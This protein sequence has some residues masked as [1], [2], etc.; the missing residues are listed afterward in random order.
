MA[1]REEL[2][3]EAI[4]L[5][6]TNLGEADRLLDFLT[7]EGRVTALARSV[8]KEKSRLAGGIELF[9]LS[10]IQVHHSMKTDRNTLT[11]AKMKKFY[12]RILGDLSTLEFASSALKDV[13]R[14]SREVQTLEFG[15]GVCGVS[16]GAPAY[17][18]ILK[19][20]LGYLDLENASLDLASSWFYLNLEHEKGNELNLMF[21]TTGERLQSESTYTWDMLEMALKPS[22]GGEIT[23]NHIKLMRLML[24]SPLALCAKVVGYDKLLPNI[25][26]IVRALRQK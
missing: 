4:V 13:E 1:G 12:R 21:D 10:E 2:K 25:N 22:A 15:A 9:C 20:L 3:T 18:S 14:A 11:A 17:F 26:P 5:R 16:V 6:R 24:T 19:Q 8:R 7:P 23:A